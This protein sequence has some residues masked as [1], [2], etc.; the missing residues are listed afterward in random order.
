MSD[1]SKAAPT[2]PEE[3]RAEVEL[4]FGRSVTLRATA[5][6]TPLGILSVAA[7]VSGIL[8]STAGVVWSA[9]RRPY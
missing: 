7:L 9:R 5:R 2:N 3:M 1:V 4:R 8:V 6:T